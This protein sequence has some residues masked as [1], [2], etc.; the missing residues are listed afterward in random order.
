MKSA[1]VRRVLGIILV[2]LLMAVA[3]LAL[4]RILAGEGYQSVY[5]LFGPV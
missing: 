4:G 2:F 3:G 1:Q 5:E